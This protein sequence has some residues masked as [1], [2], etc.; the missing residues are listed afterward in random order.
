MDRQA[1]RYVWTAAVIVLL[2]VAIYLIRT[3]LFVFIVA[4]LLA[5]LLSP[6]VDQLQRLMPMG[7]TRTPALIL[8][9]LIL[10]AAVVLAAIGL[11]SRIVDEANNLINRLPELIKQAAS[12]SPRAA[13]AN[14]TMV[15]AVVSYAQAQIRQHA[16]DF[17]AFLSRAGLRALSVAGDLVYIVIVPILS[18]FLL[19]DAGTMR[20]TVLGLVAEGRNRR[21]AEDIAR[22]VDVLLAQYM[23]ALLVLS[24]FTLTFYSFY[25][26]V[27]RVPYALLLAA[28]AG[29][30]EFI[31]LVGPLTAT[32][33]VLVVAGFTGYE[34]WIWILV[35]LG[36]Y[37]LFQ[38]YVLSPRLMS[39]GM[40]L[41]PL[42]VLFGVF[43]G[44]ELGGIPGT[45]LSVPLLALIRI[46]YLRL[47]KVRHSAK[48]PPVSS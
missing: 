45:F 4:L 38:D 25:F 1:A 33:L 29:I 31:P 3:T 40:E 26:S 34:H 46:L 2:L 13:G 36:L 23:R 19:K 7:R 43:A 18:F 30:L 37:R 32:V 21:L 27:T 28:I 14:Q 8:A 44:G 17:V 9:Y 47:V 39:Q 22:D 5:Y 20:E 42:M 11:G 35:F 12:G 41:H 24:L 48:H 15:G 6:L 10:T 16:S